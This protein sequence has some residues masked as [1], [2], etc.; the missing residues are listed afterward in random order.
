MVDQNRWVE[1]VASHT[2][3]QDGCVRVQLVPL[4]DEERDAFILEDV[5]DYAEQLQ[6]DRALTAEAALAKA[7]DELDAALRLEHAT[8][9]ERGHRRF[10]A[11]D[12]SGTAVGWLWVTPFD[13]PTTPGVAFLYQLTVKPAMRR[14][15]FG[16]AMLAALEHRLSADGIDELRLNVNDGNVRARRLYVR[17]GYHMVRRLDGKRQLRKRLG[18]TD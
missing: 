16:A 4:T 18:T 10:T 17:A 13:A 14:R 11:I 9:A 5:V 1:C 3:A 2:R 7:G 15:G 8:A 6:R 12:T